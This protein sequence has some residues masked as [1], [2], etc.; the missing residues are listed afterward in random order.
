MQ[1]DFTLRT[2]IESAIAAFITEQITKRFGWPSGLGA[3]MSIP[4]GLA[5][6]YVLNVHSPFSV[7]NIFDYDRRP[8]RAKASHS[9]SFER[10]PHRFHYAPDVHYYY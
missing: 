4:I 6:H 8:S 9:Q 10:H 2:L 5:I 7:S 1:Q 3:L